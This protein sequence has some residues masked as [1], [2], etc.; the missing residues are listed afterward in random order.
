[1]YERCS[2][3]CIA[4]NGEGV[5]KTADILYRKKYL[6]LTSFCIDG[7]KRKI[8]IPYPHFDLD[9]N[10]AL[11]FNLRELLLLNEKNYPNA[12]VHFLATLSIM[13]CST[14]CPSRN[15]RFCSGLNDA[16]TLKAYL[17]HVDLIELIKMSRESLCKPILF[18]KLNYNY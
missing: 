12:E 11:N 7:S 1:M 10:W 2:L 17:N 5:I 4:N 14:N 13:L 18:N 6:S 15:S 16:N 9:D 8:N 3:F